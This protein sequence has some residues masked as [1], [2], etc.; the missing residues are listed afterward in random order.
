VPAPTSEIELKDGSTIFLREVRP[1]DRG[2]IEAGFEGLSPES[3]YRRFFTAMSRLSDADLTYLT[4]VDHHDHEAVIAF[5]GED[6]PVGVA[7]YVRVDPP[8]EAEVAV[9]VIDAWQGK[10]AGTALVERLVQRARENGIERFVATVLA[11]NEDAID[12]FRGLSPSD[13]RPRRGDPGQVQ[14]VIDLPADGVEG[15][16]LERALR[17]AA[18]GRVVIHP[19]RLI[20]ERLQAI[21]EGRPG[22]ENRPDR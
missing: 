17:A 5:D 15:T 22:R 20:K 8:E 13:P 12:L 4:D 6:G 18:S 11:E 3:R 16:L 9:A 14:L 7:R 21:Y 10:G 1:T 2:A 19:W